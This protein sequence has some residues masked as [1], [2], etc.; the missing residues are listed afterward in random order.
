MPVSR[1]FTDVEGKDD[2]ARQTDEELESRE[3]LSLASHY[4]R[5]ADP[6][7]R[8]ALRAFAE[9]CA[10]STDLPSMAEK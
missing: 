5:I 9:A 1:F 6:E 10:Q 3:A 7:A 4:Q 8:A 2:L